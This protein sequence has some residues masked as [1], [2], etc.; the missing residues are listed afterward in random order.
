MFVIHALFGWFMTLTANTHPYDLPA[1]PTRQAI[2][3]ALGEL[4][5]PTFTTAALA[6]NASAGIPKLFWT[7]MK[8]LPS[9]FQ[10]SPR[11]KLFERPWIA[12]TCERNPTYTYHM[13]EDDR[14]D[15][16]FAT[17]FADTS[18]LW[19]FQ[20][21]NPA[22]GAARADLFR[23]SILYCFGGVYF[24]SDVVVGK[25]CPPIQSNPNHTYCF[26]T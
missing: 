19:A 14:L 1:L 18:V 21:I 7:T 3:Q 2:I 11:E 22:L 9:P 13:I 23:Y 5:D 17:V 4:N 20:M 6:Y 15:R 10:L 25:S 8:Q 26:H 12:E 24:D 16:F